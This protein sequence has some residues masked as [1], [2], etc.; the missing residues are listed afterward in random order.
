MIE[1]QVAAILNLRELAINRGSDH[2]VTEGMRFEVLDPAT[3]QVVDPETGA[4][5][6]TVRQVKVRVEV[7]AVENTWSVAQVSTSGSSLSRTYLALGLGQP[8]EART[9]K[10]GDAIIEPLTEEQ[11]YVKRGD[12]VRQIEEEGS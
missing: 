6:G 8:K 1:G 4:D 10:V 12:T 5:L 3:V 11:S 7:V 9:L 2:G